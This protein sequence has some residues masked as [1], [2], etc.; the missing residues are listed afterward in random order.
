LGG[1]ILICT[2][3]GSDN[4]ADAQFCKKCGANLG[5]NEN[6]INRINNQINLLAV[7]IGLV[8][9]IVI[10]FIGALLFGGIVTSGFNTSIYAGIVLLAMAFLGSI[11]TGILGAK[12]TNEGYIN[13]VFLSLFI[14]IIT[15]FILGILMFVF[16]GITASLANALS[17]FS[18]IASTHTTT[19]S[20]SF[21]YNWLN[22]FEVIGLIIMIFLSGGIGGALGAFIKN[23]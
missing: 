21:L 1:F 10:L 4:K 23:A 22:L 3:C 17:S 18:S 15:G 11:V 6:I 20:T 5:D 7:C 8:I 13:G 19:S 2:K 9:S 12:D 16:I 14:I